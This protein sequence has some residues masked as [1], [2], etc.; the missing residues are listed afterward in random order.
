MKTHTHTHTHIRTHAHMYMHSYSEKKFSERKQRGEHP[1]PPFWRPPLEAIA[2]S[3]IL[4]GI[5]CVNHVFEGMVVE[6]YCVRV[7]PCVCA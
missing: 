7:C 2:F 3:Y 6:S 5:Q 1:L 4:M